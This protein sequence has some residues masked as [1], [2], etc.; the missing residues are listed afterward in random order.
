MSELH[1]AWPDLWLGLLSPPHPQASGWGTHGLWFTRPDIRSKLMCPCHHFCACLCF[2]SIESKLPRYSACI[3]GETMYG[4]QYPG[5]CLLMDV[6]GEWSGHL[7][8][9]TC[10]PGCS[11]GKRRGLDS[12]FLSTTDNSIKDNSFSIYSLSSLKPISGTYPSS[13]PLGALKVSQ[14]NPSIMLSCQRARL[15][16][17]SHT[18]F[19]PQVGNY[20]LSHLPFPYL[21]Q[22]VF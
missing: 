14:R 10:A 22:L 4:N 1:Q 15:H 17:Y 11:R 16:Q 2:L 20:T 12:K 21:S 18:F 6:E 3:R 9:E 5:M 19:S 13:G 8:S 7:W